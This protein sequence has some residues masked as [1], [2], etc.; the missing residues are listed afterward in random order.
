MNASKIYSEF[1]QHKNKENVEFEIKFLPKNISLEDLLINKLEEISD[2]KEISQTINFIKEEKTL[3]KIKELCF[4]DGE[5][6]KDKKRFYSK[7]RLVKPVFINTNNYDLKITLAEELPI[8]EINEYDF[9]RFKNRIS[10]FVDEWRLDFTHV[11][12]SYAK[13]IET[14]KSIKNKLFIDKIEEDDHKIKKEIEFEFQG[15]FITREKIN[16][17]LNKLQLVEQK[18]SDIISILNT[19]LKSR[20]DTLKKILPN[21]IEIN[22]RQYF[23]EILPIIDQF[24]VTDKIDGLRTI[25][26]I[27]EET[28]KYFDTKTNNLEIQE[29]YLKET[30]IECEKVDEIFYMYDIVKYN[31]I[32]VSNEAFKDRIE[33]LY[34]LNS[35]F[36]EKNVKNIKI[37]VFMRLSEENYSEELS[38]MIESPKEYET[39]GIIFTSANNKYLE[40]KYFKWK[41]LK[42]TTI[43]FL[44]KKCPNELLGVSPYVVKQ[45]KTLYILFCGISSKEYKKLGLSKIKY[46]NKL[47]S[48]IN[49]KYF[50][51]QFCPSNNPNTYLFW[52]DDKNLDNKIV[53]LNFSQE[54]N[55]VKIRDDRTVDYSKN[56]NS[57]V[58]YYGNNFRVAE[59]IYRNYFNPLSKELLITKIE[60]LEKQFYFVN[61]DSQEHLSVRKFNNYVKTQIINRFKKN[62][63]E[64]SWLIDIASGKG[65]D[66]Y[67]FINTGVRNIL[68]IDNNENNLCEIIKRKYNYANNN[69]FDDSQVSIFIKNIDINEPYVDN[70]SDLKRNLQINKSETKLIVCNFAIHYFVKNSA[71]INNFVNFVNNLMPSNSRLIISCLNGK[72]IYDLLKEN[73]E[74][75][76]KIR[77]YISCDNLGTKFTTGKEIDILLP[78]SNGNLYKEYLVDIDGLIKKFNTKKITLE[79]RIEF[80]S[81]LHSFKTDFNSKYKLDEIDT[82]YIEYLECLIFWKK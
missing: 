18:S 43:D 64:N 54:W 71:S 70:L 11:I 4:I 6:Q 32:N 10:Y 22:K 23:E 44:C 8:Q 40:T 72:K 63:T 15:E 9:I 73:K 48:F 60:E 38:N 77:Y 35:L 53:E 62:M 42:N 24:Y 13:D 57:G 12:T 41:P 14:I 78:F 20:G 39:D 27:N 61:N 7:Q 29:L 5:Q 33:H 80:T 81:Y 52:H 31:G 2:K 26:Y 1:N 67:K 3:S 46:Y 34:K 58:N 17:L 49:N 47:F 79:S 74:W 50:P 30:I 36:E 66:L 25:L 68:C 51:I 37:K 21:A 45:D 69:S 75:G 28:H 55:L 56:T 16:L 19:E 59:I 82:Q 76:D 65:Q